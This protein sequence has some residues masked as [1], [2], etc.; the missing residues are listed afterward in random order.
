MCF[1]QDANIKTF[2]HSSYPFVIPLLRAELSALKSFTN[3]NK[4]CFSSYLLAKGSS[5][6]QQLTKVIPESEKLPH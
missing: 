3:G 1:I 4:H 6:N 2:Q 5:F